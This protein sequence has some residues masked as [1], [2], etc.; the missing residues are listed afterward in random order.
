M[1][2][3]NLFTCIFL[4]LSVHDSSHGDKYIKKVFFSC[5]NKEFFSLLFVSLSI[6][7]EI[8]NK[9]I[10][11]SGGNENFSF[12]MCLFFFGVNDFFEDL[13]FLETL[14]INLRNLIHQCLKSFEPLKFLNF[15]INN[16]IRINA[17]KKGG[18]SKIVIE[19]L[20]HKSRTVTLASVC[21]K[22]QKC[23]AN[24]WKNSHSCV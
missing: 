14:P 19:M 24:N 20:P 4:T 5:L 11:F 22:S 3:I 23:L 9:T 8:E 18:C 21:I 17:H 12:Y 10:F 13:V 16:F 15:L 1:T 7:Y 6:I 2:L